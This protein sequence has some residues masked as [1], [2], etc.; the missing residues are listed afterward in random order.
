MCCYALQSRFLADIRPT[1]LDE[2]EAEVAELEESEED[3]AE[4]PSKV[5]HPQLCS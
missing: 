2:G 4:T 5:D 3:V 1:Q